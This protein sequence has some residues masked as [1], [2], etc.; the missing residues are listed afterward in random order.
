MHQMNIAKEILEKAS[1]GVEK[2]HCAGCAS[3]L[4]T[5]LII[6]VQ[7]GENDS[8]KVSKEIYTIAVKYWPAK[9]SKRLDVALFEDFVNKLQQ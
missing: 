5:V 3:V 2:E 9:K 7:K 6:L 8:V 1:K 4:I